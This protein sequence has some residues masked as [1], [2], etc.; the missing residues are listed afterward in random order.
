MI[1]KI[2]ES[3]D[4]QASHD[5][6]NA[7][8][9]EITKFAFQEHNRENASEDDE[10]TTK[11]LKASRAGHGESDVHSARGYHVTHGWQEK[12]ERIEATI[13]FDCVR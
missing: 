6:K 9:V 10:C 5:Q 3:N 11:H 13:A 1:E 2:I 4:D 8:P 12:D 7:Q